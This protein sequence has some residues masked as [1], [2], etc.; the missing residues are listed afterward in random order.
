MKNSN[1]TVDRERRSSLL[2]I[3]FSFTFLSALP[4]NN[5]A[6]AATRLS[7]RRLLR[8]ALED[9]VSNRPAA[10]QIGSIYLAARPDEENFDRLAGDFIDSSYEGDSEILRQRDRKSTRLNS[11]HEWISRMP[12]SA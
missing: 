1:D 3:L 7:P 4:L 11:S 8:R 5:K 6:Q 10:E 2:W 12:S 9:I